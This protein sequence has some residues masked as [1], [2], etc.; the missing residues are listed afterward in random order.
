MPQMLK[1]TNKFWPRAIGRSNLV[2]S[3][4]GSDPWEAASAKS[5]SH[6]TNKFCELTAHGTRRKPSPV[7][8]RFPPV[9][10]TPA[11]QLEERILCL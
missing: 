6:W 10:R 7:S 8:P 2:P 5:Q 3:S 1:T 9:T 11:L 4:T